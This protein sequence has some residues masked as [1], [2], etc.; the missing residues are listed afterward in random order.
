MSLANA[1]GQVVRET[2]IAAA[3]SQEKLAGQAGLHRTYIGDLENGRK[4]P[5]LDVVEKIG[6]ALGMPAH[7]LLGI[8]EARRKTTRAMTGNRKRRP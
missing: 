5:T 7:E 1:F 4:S 2:R 3:L 6:T 8:A